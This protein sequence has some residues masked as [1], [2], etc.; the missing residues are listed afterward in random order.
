[1]D[2]GIADRTAIVTGAGG[3]LGG[4]IVKALAGEG[5]KVAACDISAEALEK[6]VAE[7]DGG[8]SPYAFDLA[9]LGALESVVERVRS[10]LGTPSILV[11]ITGGPPPAAA[12]ET[13]VEDWEKYF[14]A[15][16]SP[17]IRLAGLLLPDMRTQGWGR[18]ITS[19][20][21]GVVTPIPNLA[22]SNGLRSSLVGWSKTLAG[23]VAE[24][25]VTVN[26]VVP[27][28]IETQRVRALDEA[29]AKREGLPVEEVTAA[30][31]A[32]IPARRYGRPDEYADVVVFLASE[33]ASYVNGAMIRV[34]GG[35]IP[36]I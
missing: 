10:D 17:V 35:L 27:G 18:I 1:M 11:G 24:D 12:L 14:R 7:S 8:V 13:R 22:L 25:G 23:E 21:S 34:D 4:A 28:R 5:A 32:T 26:V 15:L 29:K 20:S 6:T 30:S 3:G 9:D 19:T 16:V 36:S 2:L 31:T 33:R